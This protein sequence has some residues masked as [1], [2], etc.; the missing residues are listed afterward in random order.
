MTAFAWQSSWSSLVLAAQN[1]HVNVMRVLLE[2]KANVDLQCKVLSEEFGL[3]PYLNAGYRARQ[4]GCRDPGLKECAGP[5]GQK[6]GRGLGA[7]LS[8]REALVP[9]G[10]RGFESSLVASSHFLPSR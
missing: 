1:G 9:F 3:E 6:G 5:A 10:P 7:L 4:A 2:G 8:S